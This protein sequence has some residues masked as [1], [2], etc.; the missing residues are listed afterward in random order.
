MK[1]TEAQRR[2]IAQRGSW[3]FDVNLGQGSGN[4][5]VFPGEG[6]PDW[7]KLIEIV[8]SG[9]HVVGF[10]VTADCGTNYSVYRECDLEDLQAMRGL[11]ISW[12]GTTAKPDVYAP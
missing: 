4:S 10:K 6:V 12:Y 1:L 9:A 3:T 11:Y 7:D 8:A 5:F 2:V